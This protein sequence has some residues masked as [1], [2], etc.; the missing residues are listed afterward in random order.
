MFVHIDSTAIH[1]LN[2][3]EENKSEVKLLKANG[4]FL[5][6]VNQPIR[7]HV[8]VYI[9]KEN[10]SWLA[11]TSFSPDDTIEVAGTITDLHDNTIT[12]YTLFN[13]I[14]YLLYHIIQCPY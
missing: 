5:N 2:V 12:V 11:T 4:I 9:P 1:V 7:V 8:E 6:F 14:S 10:P 13:I 3:N